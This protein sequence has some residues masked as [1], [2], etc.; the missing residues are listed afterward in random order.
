VKAVVTFTMLLHDVPSEEDG[1]A[2]A[3]SMRAA[4]FHNATGILEQRGI[5]ADEICE[6]LTFFEPIVAFP[7]SLQVEA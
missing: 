1:H 5:R 7:M 4:A 2:A 6:Y 3:L